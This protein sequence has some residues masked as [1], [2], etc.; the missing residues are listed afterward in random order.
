MSDLQ[1]D[2]RWIHATSS[3]WFAG[4]DSGAVPVAISPMDWIVPP[5]GHGPAVRAEILSVEYP[6][7]RTEDYQL[8]LSYRT[9]RIARACIGRGL[10]EGFEW[11]H[12]AVRDPQAIAALIG[13]TTGGGHGR[14]WQGHLEAGL[15]ADLL[16]IRAFEGEQS[17]SS[18]FLG[19]SALIKFFRRLQP[20][21][22][23][24]IELHEALA[25]AGVTS[26]DRLLGSLSGT[27]AEGDSGV[28]VDLAMITT[29]IRGAQ[30]GW[31]LATAA[32]GRGEDF[33]SQAGRLGRA[34]GSVHAALAE[35]LG[36]STLNGD[37]IADAMT[38][39]LGS[40][41]AE[42]PQL[43]PYAERLSGLFDALRGRRL[44]AQRVH[45]DFHLGQTL[46]GDDGWH[47]IDFEG[48]PLRPLDERRRPD[49]PLRDVAGMIRSFGYA[50]ATATGLDPPARA[51]WERAC[52]ESF[53]ASIL[54]SRPGRS[55]DDTLNAY[56]ADKAV[57]EVVYEHRNR[58]D[59][60]H[61]PLNALE[62][63]GALETS[64]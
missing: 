61:I 43:A 47:I 50:A 34:L 20:G 8:L 32:A 36:T 56:V 26:T 52:V 17:N 35:Q 64:D 51:D 63:L 10:A 16:P 39:R 30:D 12:D 58:P 57:Y 9:D 22:N 18:V 42:V 45:G 27:L 3:R 49:S 48:E 15:P 44:P 62:T 31:G 19:H 14:D 29:R 5:G 1:E 59:W 33:S 7:G 55:E 4:K 11:V 54:D 46:F 38:A 2:P 23:I 13:A 25:R 53:T 37:G 6:D 28:R 41:L 60:V 24:D 21:R 40:A